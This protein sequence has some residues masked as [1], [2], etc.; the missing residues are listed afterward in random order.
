MEITDRMV[1][2]FLVKYNET[3]PNLDIPLHLVFRWSMKAA[4]E[5]DPPK[6]VLCKNCKKELELIGQSNK[7]RHKANKSMFCYLEMQ[8]E[9]E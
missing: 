3:Y 4:L 7:W 2:K 5:P 9:P 8:A 6:P 1:E